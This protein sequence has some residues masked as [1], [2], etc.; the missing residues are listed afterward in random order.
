MITIED[1]IEFV[2]EN[3]R[4]IV[5][6]QEML[7]DVRS[8]HSALRHVL[9]QDPDVIVIGE[10]RDLET[11]ETALIGAETGHLVMAT[12]HTPDSIQT[13]QRIYSVFP[14]HQQNSITVQ[15]ANSIQAILPQKLLP[16]ADGMGRVLASEICIATNAVRN[17]IRE[18]QVHL[19]YNELQTGRKH[20]M[21]TMDQ[22][23][24][25]LYQRGEITY[26]VAL[27]NAYQPDFIRHT[28]EKKTGSQ[29]SV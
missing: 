11:I 1:P 26:D 27:T 5:V 14:P 6:Q 3:N 18:R 22:S 21:R 25:E 13:A 15:F 23:L 9:R 28:V 8:Y 4:S 20:K 19:I 17:H 29:A 24:L 12:L 7:S 10:M 16:R 2:H